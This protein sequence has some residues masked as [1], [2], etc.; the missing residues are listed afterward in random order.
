M[1]VERMPLGVLVER[2]PA[3]SRWIDHV[4]RVAG[5]VP[6]R[7]ETPAWSIVAQADGVT[8]YCAGMTELLFH[9]A[10]TKVYL[11]NLRAAQPSVY[12]VLRRA[13]TPT[14]WRLLLAT[15]DPAEAHSHA[16]VGDDLLEAVPMPR[17]VLDRLAAFVARHHVEREEWRRKRD[18]VDPE[19]LG[20][21][22]RLPRP[23]AGGKA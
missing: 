5:V 14:G 17:P 12:V 6:G 22:A 23:H 19:A 13:G 4:W 9:S 18:R 2:L 15:V 7:L 16:D 11:H 8:R 20:P 21:R 1:T 10:E 3:R